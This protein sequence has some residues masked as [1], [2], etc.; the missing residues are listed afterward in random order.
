M[1]NVVTLSSPSGKNQWFW[2]DNKIKFVMKGSDIYWLDIIDS[3][4]L[5]MRLDVTADEFW[6]TSGPT[7]FIDRLAAVLNIP[8]YRVRIVDTYEGSTYIKARILQKES[9]VGTTDSTGQKAT[10]K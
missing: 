3:I 8:T 5:T 9:L 1:G 6:A 4:Q 7:D 10:I 2:T